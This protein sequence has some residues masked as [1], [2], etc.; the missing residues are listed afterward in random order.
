MKSVQENN[1]RKRGE[2]REGENQVK[3]ENN[4]E[5]TK[6]MQLEIKNSDLYAV[7]DTLILIVHC[8]MYV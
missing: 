3:E 2:N 1:T 6:K 5:K 8:T 4:N 7:Q